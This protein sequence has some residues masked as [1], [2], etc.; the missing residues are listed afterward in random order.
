MTGIRRFINVTISPPNQNWAYKN[1]I[2]AT[3]LKNT[4]L[5]TFFVVSSFYKSVMILTLTRQSNPIRS[6]VITNTTKS[7]TITSEKTTGNMKKGFLFSGLNTCSIS[8]IGPVLISVA[9]I[10]V[11]E[12]IG[13]TGSLGRLPNS[14]FT[15]ISGIRRG[16]GRSLSP[17]RKVSLNWSL[18]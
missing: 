7:A 13:Y 9:Y 16:A 2:T 11:F 1:V 8:F 18:M 5:A 17:Q 14:I 4:P 6:H 12:Y 10:R 15:D 3:Q